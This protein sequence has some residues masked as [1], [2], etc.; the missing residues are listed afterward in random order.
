M[1]MRAGVSCS[2]RAGGVIKL[3][4]V[5]ITNVPHDAAKVVRELYA[6]WPQRSYIKHGYR[7]DQEQGLEWSR[8]SLFVRKLALLYN[9][10]MK[11]Y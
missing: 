7:F 9:H 5:L 10:Q 3:D 8:T 6:D 4:L 2:I 1:R 11:R